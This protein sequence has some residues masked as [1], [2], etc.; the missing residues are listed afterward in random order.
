MARKASTLP[1]SFTV[2]VPLAASRRDD[3]ILRQKGQA[4]GKLSNAL[5]AL[6]RPRFDSMRADPAW[7]AAGAARDNEARAAA[8]K[9][10][11]VRHKLDLTTQDAGNLAFAQ[12]KRSGWMADVITGQVALC[13]GRQTWSALQNWCYGHTDRPSFQPSH[14]YL[15]IRTSTVRE[16]CMLS[17]D[18]MTLRWP[19]PGRRKRKDLAIRLKWTGAER[20]K[21][22]NGGRIVSC[23]VTHRGGMWFAQIK[24]KGTPYRSAAYL[25]AARAV[26]GGRVGIDPGVSHFAAVGQSASAKIP[27]AAPGILEARRQD[28]LLERRLQRAVDRSRRASNPDCY[29][30]DGQAIKGKRPLKSSAAGRRLAKKLA[31]AQRVAAE[32]REQDAVTAARQIMLLGGRIATEANDFRTWQASRYGKRMGLTRPGKIKDAIKRELAVVHGRHLETVPQSLGLS[33]FCFCGAKAKKDLSQRTHSCPVCGIGPLDRDLTSALLVRLISERPGPIDLSAGPLHAAGTKDAHL[34]VVGAAPAD[35][36]PHPRREPK[37]PGGAAAATDV[38]PRGNT[39][40][41]R[42]RPGRR[43]HLNDSPATS[44]DEL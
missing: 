40:S 2:D 32:H 25:D 19:Q 17:A 33:Q 15:S 21:R 22:L 10:L 29:K 34:C 35:H 41:A 36:P 3:V 12:W 20:D 37:P 30:A 31:R 38:R 26:V 43:H 39:A 1:D 7:R 6:W 5:L 8:F 4:A 18:T 14:E 28:A 11:R 16:G 13:V 24:V 44:P 9:A 23:G 27:L 42:A